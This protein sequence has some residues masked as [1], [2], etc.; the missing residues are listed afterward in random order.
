MTEAEPNGA[1]SFG[2]NSGA[3]EA[4]ADQ[5]KVI[6]YPI[7]LTKFVIFNV[8]TLGIFEIIWAFKHFRALKGPGKSKTA[9]AIIFAIFLPLSFFDMMKEYEAVSSDTNSPIVF[10][11]YFLAVSYFFFEAV[12][13]FADRFPSMPDWTVLA[14]FPFS[15]IPLIIVQRKINQLNTTLRPGVPFAQPMTWK[16][17][18]GLAFG[19]LVLL[20]MLIGAALLS[21]K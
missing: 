9:A 1:S 20:G 19:V 6:G 15:L 8:L 14:V 7:T 12:I 2:S 10:N 11:K 5:Q 4:L 13:K 16:H 18:L 17:W 3:I 21:D